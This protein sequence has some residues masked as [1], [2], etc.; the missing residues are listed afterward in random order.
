[1]KRFD[2]YLANFHPS[3]GAEIQKTRPCV[4]LSPN[5]L[6]KYSNTILIAPL[7]STIKAWPTRV[8]THLN[9]HDGQI[10]LQQIK[11]FDRRRFIKKLDHLNDE[12]SQKVCEILQ[13]LFAY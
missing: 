9:G 7:T 11:S 12:K 2:I 8:D 1:M 13:E 4:I 6:I 10:M 3:L 5:E